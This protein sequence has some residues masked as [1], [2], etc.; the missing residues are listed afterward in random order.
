VT[1][2]SFA[3]RVPPAYGF[4][5]VALMRP[6]EIAQ[7]T[8]MQVSPCGLSHKENGCGVSKLAK[9]HLAMGG[10]TQET[11]IV[12]SHSVLSMVPILLPLSSSKV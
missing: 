12:L 7:V 8:T 4:V 10:R 3:L 2:S 1:I 6:K 11:E 9:V 5:S